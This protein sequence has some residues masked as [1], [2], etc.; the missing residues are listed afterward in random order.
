L[1][2]IVSVK[3][4]RERD[5]CEDYSNTEKGLRHNIKWKQTKF[6]CKFFHVAQNGKITWKKKPVM[7]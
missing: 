2:G 6:V 1:A 5:Q 4:Q 3:K 7:G